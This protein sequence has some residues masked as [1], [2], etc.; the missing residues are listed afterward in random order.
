ME[1]EK[2]GKK[3]GGRIRVEPRFSGSQ[4]NERSLHSWT[5]ALKVFAR[6][7]LWELNDKKKEKWVSIKY[8]REKI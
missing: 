8:K 3:A 1:E 4:S 7:V 5:S 2:A 6:T